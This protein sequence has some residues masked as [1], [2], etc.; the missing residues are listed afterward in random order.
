MA[1][2]RNMS[3]WRIGP[4]PARKVKSRDRYSEDGEVFITNVNAQIMLT[5]A[6]IKF[7]PNG[8]NGPAFCIEP[9]Q[10]AMEQTHKEEINGSTTDE[11]APID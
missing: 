2:S 8:K 7:F 5:D 9:H 6:V 1:T 11:P 10:S 3:Y 4:I